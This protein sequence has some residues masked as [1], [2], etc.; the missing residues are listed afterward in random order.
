MSTFE[1]ATSADGTAIAFER[2]GQG[3][4]L[5]LIGGAFATRASAAG[6]AALLAPHL[7]V[8]AYD[9]RGRGDSGDAGAY[10]VEREVEDLTA[11]IRLLGGRARL[12][13]HS[14]GGILALDA[15]RSGAPVDRVAAYEPPFI[16]EG[17]PRPGA[18]LAERLRGLLAEGRRDDAVALFQSEA[19]GLPAPVIQGLRGTEMW[20]GLVAL[21]HTLPYDVEITGPG[22]AL[23]VELLAEI[24]VPTLV[25][26]GTASMAW[27]LPGTRAVAAAIP[28][29]RHVTIEGV[30]H[31]APQAHP[32]RLLPVLRDFLS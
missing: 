22:N 15:A 11:L 19:I 28:G 30:D 20:A 23:P 8:V 1:T 18:D 5:V 24:P 7:T 21:A 10:A 13:G 4:P 2:R 16:P 3:P 6:L 25:I 29:A 17:F 14:S 9:R 26:A 31:G 12:F 32:E 27:M